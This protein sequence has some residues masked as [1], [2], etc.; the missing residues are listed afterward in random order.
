MGI[1]FLKNQQGNQ[2]GSCC[3]QYGLPNLLEL[4]FGISQ[5]LGLKGLRFKYGLWPP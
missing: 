1:I 5:G 2:V 3:L 4:A